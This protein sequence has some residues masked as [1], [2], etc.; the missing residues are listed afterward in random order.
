MHWLILQEVGIDIAI[1]MAIWTAVQIT[2]SRAWKVRF[3]QPESDLGVILAIC[4]RNS[5]VLRCPTFRAQSSG[6]LF[7]DF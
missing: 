6:S 7:V 4:L 5:E 1:L 3:E 2:K